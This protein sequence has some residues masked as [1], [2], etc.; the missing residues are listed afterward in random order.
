MVIITIGASILIRGIP[1]LLLGKDTH[2][3]PAFSGND[4]LY[5]L[6]ATLLPQNLWIFGLTAAVILASKLF[7]HYSIFGKARRACA[8]NGQRLATSHQR[9]EHV[10]C[11]S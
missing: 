6:G 9:Q 1:M 10:P 7:F 5:L 3:L 8:F 2:A 11:L 4:P